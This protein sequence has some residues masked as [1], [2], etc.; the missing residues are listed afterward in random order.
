MVL[1]WIYKEGSMV[2]LLHQLVCRP[3]RFDRFWCSIQVF[4]V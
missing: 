2:C 4:T 1:V 3:M